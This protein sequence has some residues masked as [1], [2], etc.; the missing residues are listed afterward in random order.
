MSSPIERI[1]AGPRLSEAV[2]Y[3]GRTVY[4]AGQV[5]DDAAAASADIAVQTTSV[6]A[7]V[8]AML[9]K[10][11]S[12]K[13]RL[14]HATIYLTTLDDFA[15]MNAVWTA[16]LPAGCAPARA[17]VGGVRLA[18]PEWR[19]EMVVTAAASESEIPLD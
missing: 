17:T 5:P 16:W 7:Q 14:L 15:G 1:D 9:A 11:G 13:T 10:C 2:V 8:D 4:L 12:D 18:K 3:G 6:L 19:V